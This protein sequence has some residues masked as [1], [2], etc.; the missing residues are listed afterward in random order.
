M[1]DAAQKPPVTVRAHIRVRGWDKT[2]GGNVFYGLEWEV[3]SAGVNQHRR[4]LQRLNFGSSGAVKWAV[5]QLR[6]MGW[7]GTD[8]ATLDAD[9]FDADHTIEITSRVDGEKT[10]YDVEVIRAWTPKA[11]AVTPDRLSA[12]TRGNL[13]AFREVDR[14]FGLV[15]REPGDDAASGTD[16]LDDLE[17]QFQ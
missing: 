11:G 12:L 3:T 13:A 17:R 6:R 9:V 1:A 8:F 10:Y 4:V 14:E 2:Q 7:R 5:R 16:D 15:A